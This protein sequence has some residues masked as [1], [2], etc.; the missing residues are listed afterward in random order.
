MMIA[1]GGEDESCLRR[2]LEGADREIE[3]RRRE[4]S[5][6][7]VSFERLGEE[8]ATGNRDRTSSRTITGVAG[9]RCAENLM[10]V[11]RDTDNTCAPI[12]TRPTPCKTCFAVLHGLFSYDITAHA[13]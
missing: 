4:D 11:E 9:R 3:M 6:R 8:K 1:G 12:P 7:D 2:I 10:C 5:E 13:C